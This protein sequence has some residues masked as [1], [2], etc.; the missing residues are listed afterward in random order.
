MA[1]V[2]ELSRFPALA[3][4]RSVNSHGISASNSSSCNRGGLVGVSVHYHAIDR[5]FVPCRMR[6]SLCSRLHPR[7]IRTTATLGTHVLDPERKH[8]D[9]YRKELK[10]IQKANSNTKSRYNISR[11]YQRCPRKTTLT[12]A[13]FNRYSPSPNEPIAT[14][15]VPDAITH[16]NIPSLMVI[17][18]QSSP[19]VAARR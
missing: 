19:I 12:K 17:S 6:S 5:P 9:A 1:Q 2:V 4:S 13:E 10:S 11:E 16:P 18:I 7:A 3:G 14:H 8:S 15:A